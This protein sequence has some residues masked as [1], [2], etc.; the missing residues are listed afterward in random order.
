LG[1]TST[2]DT[3]ATNAVDGI[4]EVLDAVGDLD[5]LTLPG[6]DLVSAVNAARAYAFSMSIALG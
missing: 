4:N 6:A 1:D 5:D 2:L 3:T